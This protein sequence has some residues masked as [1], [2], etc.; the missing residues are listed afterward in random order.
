MLELLVI[1]LALF[2]LT[3]G[4]EVQHYYTFSL[5]LP[6]ET[7]GNKNMF[8]L[9][10][11]SGII[12]KMAICLSQHNTCLN[13]EYSSRQEIKGKNRIFRV[14]SLATKFFRRIPYQ[15]VLQKQIYLLLSQA[16]NSHN[17]Q[18]EIQILRIRGRMHDK[19][20]EYGSSICIP[21]F[22]Y[23]FKSVPKNRNGFL[24]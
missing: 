4:K 15:Q 7:G 1:K 22:Q 9:S 24:S 13:T 23:D 8:K 19:R 3:K 20:L 18:P 11:R 17:I 6:F 12:F 10:K 14:V 5:I 16:T 21:L 2:F